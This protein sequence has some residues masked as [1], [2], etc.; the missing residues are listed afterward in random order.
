MTGQDFE[1]LAA[2][3]RLRVKT[4]ASSRALRRVLVDGLT[5]EQAAILERSQVEHVRTVYA[6]AQ[7]CLKRVRA[8]QSAAQTAL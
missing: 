2:L 5:V 3:M 8:L 7:V 4:S 6:S 1:E